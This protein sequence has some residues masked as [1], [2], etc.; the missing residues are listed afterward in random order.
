MLFEQGTWCVQRGWYQITW[1]GE[2]WA[3][4]DLARR[5]FVD[6][7]HASG[8][9]ALATQLIA[10]KTTEWEQREGYKFFVSQ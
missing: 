3:V 10:D 7:K 9:I 4:Y 8:E 6:L 2:K 1:D 5:H